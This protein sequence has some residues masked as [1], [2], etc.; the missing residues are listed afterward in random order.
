ML[1]GWAEAPWWDGPGCKDAEAEPEGQA[2]EMEL[3]GFALKLQEP[4]PAAQEPE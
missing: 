4:T 3:S 2:A 1:L